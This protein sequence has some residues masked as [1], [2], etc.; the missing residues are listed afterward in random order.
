MWLQNFR[1][2]LVVLRH[3]AM[4][5][6]YHRLLFHRKIGSAYRALHTLNADL[7]SINHLG[8][9]VGWYHEMTPL[10]PEFPSLP[11]SSQCEHLPIEATR[12]PELAGEVPLH[13][14]V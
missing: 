3:G 2:N 12:C 10:Q 7:R 13:Q 1:W 9:A 6:K 14:T 8:H 5:S 4:H 11:F